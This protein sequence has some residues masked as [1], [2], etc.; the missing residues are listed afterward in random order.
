M[1]VVVIEVEDYTAM[2][3]LSAFDWAQLLDQP[4]V[5]VDTFET[6]QEL[7]DAIATTRKGRR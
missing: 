6:M 7:K 4:T 3:L 5:R 2:D 1:A